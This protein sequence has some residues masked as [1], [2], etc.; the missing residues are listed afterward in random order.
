MRRA[1]ARRFAVSP[2]DY[3]ARFSRR[4]PRAGIDLDLLTDAWSGSGA[5]RA[6]D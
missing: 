6:E 2:G 5:A 3:R 4:D 1:F